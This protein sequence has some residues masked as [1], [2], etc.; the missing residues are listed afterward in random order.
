M[1]GASEVFA[2]LALLAAV[3]EGSDDHQVSSA[4]S[5]QH[6]F[7]EQT[8]AGVAINSDIIVRN[9]SKAALELTGVQLEAFDAAG[10]L[11]LRKELNEDGTSPSILTI[12][13]RRVEASGTLLIYNPFPEF[14]RAFPVE[15]LHFELTFKGQPSNRAIHLST[16][17]MPRSPPASDYQFPVP[18]RVLV[19]D[20][21]DFYSHHRR[22]NYLHPVLMKRGYHGNAGRYAYDFITIDAHGAS[23]HGDPAVNANWLSFGQPVSAPADGVI[24]QVRSTAKDDRTFHFGESQDPNAIFGNYVVI[25]H[26]D[27]TF[28]LSGHLMRGS[29]V[30]RNGDRVSAGQLI[31]RIGASGDALFPHLHYQRALEPTDLGEGVPVSWRGVDRLI[32]A[33]RSSLPNGYINTGDIVARR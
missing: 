10:H 25:S 3:S 7:T 1:M 32:G 29:V 15:R 9:N 22:W 27:G 23:V 2:A 19:W 26:P 28:S 20:G 31:G 12:P 13:D 16:D 8:A 21:H 33:K 18:G 11:L 24:V 6:P 5:P 14:D 4:S 30:V 17:V